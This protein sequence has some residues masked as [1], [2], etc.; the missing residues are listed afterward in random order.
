LKNEFTNDER[1]LIEDTTNATLLW[2]EEHLD[3]DMEAL[4]EKQ[5]ELW[6]IFNPIMM[7]IFGEAFG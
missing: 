7:R 6:I 3:A 1:K 2:I 5:K 4:Q